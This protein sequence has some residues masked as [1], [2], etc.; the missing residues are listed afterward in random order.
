MGLGAVTCGSSLGLGV[1]EEIRGKFAA[2]DDPCPCCME[3]FLRVLLIHRIFCENGK[4]PETRD[5]TD[6]GQ[7]RFSRPLSEN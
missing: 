2:D 4:S 7:L 1:G 5:D 3:P 6:Q